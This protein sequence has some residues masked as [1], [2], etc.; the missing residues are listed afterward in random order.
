VPAGSPAGVTVDRVLYQRS[1]EIESKLDLA[2][3]LIASG[4]YSTPLLA[5]ALAVSV[6]TVSRYVKAL[7]QRGYEI[8]PERENDGWRYA[9]LTSRPQAIKSSRSARGKWLSP[10]EERRIA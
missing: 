1:H 3:Q 5:E 4:R 2:L 10:I 7:R 8:R 6:P 9:L